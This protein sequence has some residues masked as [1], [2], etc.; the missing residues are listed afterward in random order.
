MK[1]FY[2]IRHGVTKYNANHKFVG[3]TDLSLTHDGIKMIK[4]LWDERKVHF[5]HEILYSSP[6]KRCIETASIIFPGENINTVDNFREMDFG[7][8]EG[9]THEDLMDMDAYKEFRDSKGRTQIPKGESGIEFGRRVLRGFFEVVSDMNSK[10][11]NVAAI[12]CHGGVIMA[13]FSLLCDESDDIYHYYLNN[14]EG[15]S[16]YYDEKLKKI[17]INEKI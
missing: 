10:E 7:I 8:F 5:D 9:K 6:M 13:L 14:G 4:D 3:S 12:V 2:F 17:L 11:K 1:L 16:V 15:Y